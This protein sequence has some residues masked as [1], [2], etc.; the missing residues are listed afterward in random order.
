VLFKGGIFLSD[1]KFASLLPDRQTAAF[2]LFQYPDLFML[3]PAVTDLSGNLLNLVSNR[4][5]MVS[6]G[7]LNS[8]SL[9][10]FSVSAQFHRSFTHDCRHLIAN[11]Q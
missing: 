1:V 9:G 2:P 5:S 8:T 11:P 6:S 7:L 4:L 10:K 3:S